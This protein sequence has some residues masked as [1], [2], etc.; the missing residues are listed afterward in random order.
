MRVCR[1]VGEWLMLSQLEGRAITLP[2]YRR[3]YD[4]PERS[5]YR[6]LAEFRDLFGEGWNDFDDPQPL[7]DVIVAQLPEDRPVWFAKLRKL[8]Q[9][10]ERKV[11]LRDVDITALLSVPVTL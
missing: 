5:A 11:R 6:H 2:E 1:F 10:K 8:Y 4:E 9:D 7:V 3:F